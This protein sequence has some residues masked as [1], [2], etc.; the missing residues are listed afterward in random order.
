MLGKLALL[1]PSHVQ[2]LLLFPSRHLEATV[3]LQYVRV[4]FRR[5]SFGSIGMAMLM[6]RN[7]KESGPCT[8]RSTI[9]IL[10]P[11]D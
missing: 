2:I 4:Q 11:A 9:A 6:V 1:D 7:L 5:C 8:L 3:Y 10:C